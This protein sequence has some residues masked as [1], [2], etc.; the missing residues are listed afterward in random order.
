MNRAEALQPLLPWALQ[1]RVRG[2]TREEASFPT[3]GSLSTPAPKKSRAPLWVPRFPGLCEVVVVRHPGPGPGWPLALCCVGFR[4]STLSSRKGSRLRSCSA[5]EVES[6]R[7]LPGPWAHC[8][9][10]LCREVNSYQQGRPCAPSPL[11]SAW[12][13]FLL[14]G[15]LEV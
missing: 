1:Q 2:R 7:S 15:A 11:L 5:L 14:C 4:A 3:T 9:C 10:L 6:H 8:P 13:L 12:S